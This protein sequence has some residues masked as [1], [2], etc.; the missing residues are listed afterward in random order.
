MLYPTVQNI[1]YGNY[2]SEIK[3][4]TILVPNSSTQSAYGKLY[5]VQ[6]QAKFWRQLIN[7]IKAGKNTV[8]SLQTKYH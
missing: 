2:S 8:Q 1:F 7:S 3:K 5:T 6:S 4:A